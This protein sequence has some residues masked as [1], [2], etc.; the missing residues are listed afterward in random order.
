MTEDAASPPDLIGLTADVVAAYVANNKVEASAAPTLIAAVHAAFAG[1]GA[2]ADAGPVPAPTPAVSLRKS[3]ADRDRIVSMIDGR[4][5]SSLK[6]HLAAHGLSP[7]DYRA[8]YN[9]PA[10]Y[11]MVAPG[12]SERRRTLAKAIG[13]GRKAAVTEPASTPAKPKGRGRKAAAPAP[14]IPAVRK[15]RAKTPPA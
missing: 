15:R 12:Y 2:S 11:P 7:G 10:D 8:R 1:L 6:R 13:L 4:A 9:L 5:Y 3:L 14:E